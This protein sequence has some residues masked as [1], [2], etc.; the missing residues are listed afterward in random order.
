MLILM[1]LKFHHLPAMIH[2]HHD[3]YS[4]NK[5]AT[6]LRGV[7]VRLRTHSWC[8]VLW[9]KIH[10]L[11]GEI[12]RCFIW[13]AYKK[14]VEFSPMLFDILGM[15]MIHIETRFGIYDA[16]TWLTHQNISNTWY[17]NVYLLP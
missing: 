6:M 7:C 11:N 10:D 5:I 13:S 16:A 15:K 8:L 2:M 1:T 12:E 3:K 4:S 14:C 17:S 9:P